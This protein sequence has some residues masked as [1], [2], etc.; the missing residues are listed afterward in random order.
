MNDAQKLALG[1]FEKYW[2]VD[3]NFQDELIVYTLNGNQEIRE[4]IIDKDGVSHYTTSYPYT[5]KLQK[6]LQRL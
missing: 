3:T 2:I 1:K 4:Y 5:V 6:E